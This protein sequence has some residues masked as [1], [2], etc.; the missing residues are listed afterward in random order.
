ML[1]LSQ[2]TG[3][4]VLA[5]SCLQQCGCDLVLAKDIADCTGIPLPYLLK[6]LHAMGKAGMVIAKRG[7][8]GGF[9]L[10]RPAEKISLMDVA[11]AVDG[12]AWMPKCLLGLDECSDERQ[13]PTHHFW[14]IQRQQIEAKLR[15][16]TI[17][18]V[19]E[20]EARQAR[21]RLGQCRAPSAGQGTAKTVA[22]R[23]TARVGPTSTK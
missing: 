23:R 4:A 6:L 9:A 19:A 13:C 12:K 11:E 2:T 8:R 21:R 16:T 10:A 22:G 7:Y 15:Q 3:Y 20:H 18:D 14:K 5:L 1:S 17:Q